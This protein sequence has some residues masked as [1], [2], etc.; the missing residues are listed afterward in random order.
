MNGNVQIADKLLNHDRLKAVLLS[1]VR[2]R[3][4]HNVEQLGDD[5]GDAAEETGTRSALAHAVAALDRDVG[6]VLGDSGVHHLVSRRKNSIA[7]SRTRNDTNRTQGTQEACSPLPE[8]E[9]TRQSPHEEQT[10]WGSRKR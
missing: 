3:R 9:D 8:Y 2:V 4:L 1:E 6:Q 5:G 7:T 10:A